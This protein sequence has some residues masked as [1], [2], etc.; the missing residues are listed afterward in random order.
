MSKQKKDV[1]FEEQYIRGLLMNLELLAHKWELINTKK[2][3][4]R[5]NAANIMQTSDLLPKEAC[6]WQSFF[7]LKTLK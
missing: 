3:M 2:Y 6:G 7:E 1:H 4:Y 5:R